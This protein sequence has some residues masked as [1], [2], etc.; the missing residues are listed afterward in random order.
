MSVFATGSPYWLRVNGKW[1]HLEGVTPGVSDTADRPSSDLLVLGGRRYTSRAKRAAREWSLDFAHATPEA[2]RLLALAAHGQAGDVMLLDL[3]AA[4]G[5]MLDPLDCVGPGTFPLLECDGTLLRSVVPGAS[6][7][8]VVP[9]AAKANAGTTSGGVDSSTSLRLQ[10]DLC[11]VLLKYAVPATPAGRTLV[12]ARLVLE[13]ASG[14]SPTITALAASNAWVEPAGL[15]DAGNRWVNV[16]FGATVGSAAV[17]AGTPVRWSIPLTGVAAF[18]GADMSLL[19]QSSLSSVTIL[20]PRSQVAAA[21]RLELTYSVAAADLLMD[22][23]IRGGI[24]HQL[25]A[26]TTAPE[27]ASFMS[28]NAGTVWVGVLAPSGSGPRFVSTEFTPAA[29]ADL[30]VIVGGSAGGVTS[31]LRLTEG[32]HIG[33]WVPGQKTPCRVSV[34]DRERTLNHLLV[35]EQ[36]RSD[37]RVTLKEV[38]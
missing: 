18:A 16:S 9:V 2:V 31:A 28:Y 6:A 3:S 13:R 24:A 26:Y 25:S 5:N 7:T 19:L 22:A 12:S 14:A 1:M 27:G 29:D 36:G 11:E 32:P 21:P 10:K 15:S 33:R 20:Q 30:G 23:P 37:Y 8:E 17:T 35:G 38:G 4:R 34:A